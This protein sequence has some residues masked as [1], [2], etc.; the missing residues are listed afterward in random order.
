MPAPSN[1]DL[2]RPEGRVTLATVP[3]ERVPPVEAAELPPGPRLSGSAIAALALAA[4]LASIALG[5]WAFG[6][7]VRSD[8]SSGIVPAQPIFGAAQAISTLSKPT[9]ARLPLA[10]SDG[11]A[12]LAVAADGRGLLVLDGLGIAPVGRSYQ[13]WVVTPGPRNAVPLSAAVF[14][15]VETIVPLS[16]RVVPGSVVGI[17]IE[18]AGGA[19]APT[20]GL[21]LTAQRAP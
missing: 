17:T 10:G 20:R 1:V 19:P 15:G 3:T 2:R 7:S 11:K 5:A 8:D 13:A 9:T 4:G 14:T 16:A 6:T 12:I 18:R 21:E